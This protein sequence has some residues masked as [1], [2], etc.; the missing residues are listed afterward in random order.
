ML[1]D[2]Q[3]GPL[4]VGGVAGIAAL[5]VLLLLRRIARHSRT[6]P[7]APALWHGRDYACPR[8]GTGMQPG[9]VLLGKGAIWSDRARGK[10]GAFAHIGKALPNTISLN[11]RP[12]ANMAWRCGG[13]RMLLIDHDKLVR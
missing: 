10:P 9:W 6:V 3:L 12:A 4:L 5:S 7:D 11:L 13:C 1:N 8:C 2:P